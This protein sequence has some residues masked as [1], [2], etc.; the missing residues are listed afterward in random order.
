MALKFCL[1]NQ[2]KLVDFCPGR[3]AGVRGGVAD[4]K[5]AELAGGY[6]ES[7]GGVEV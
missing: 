4:G 7:G 5:L 1:Q 3:I 2:P 6:E